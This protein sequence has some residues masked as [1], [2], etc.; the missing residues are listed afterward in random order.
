M[1]AV[2]EPGT[3]RVLI[4]DDQRVVREGLS[5]LVA[6]ID[7]VQVVGT[8][9]DG[10]EAVRLAEAHRPDVVLMDLVELAADLATVVRPG[11]VPGGVDR[12]QPK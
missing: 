10:A 6:L 9:C 11:Q 12:V 2:P 4:A 7:D 5:M 1:T 8:A 3:I